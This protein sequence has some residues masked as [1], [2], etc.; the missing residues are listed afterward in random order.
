M[1]VEKVNG[2]WCPVNESTRGGVKLT[3]NW[4]QFAKLVRP[5]LRPNEI[6]EAIKVSDYGLELTLKTSLK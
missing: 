3:V 2:R 6:I 4:D 1:R 5:D